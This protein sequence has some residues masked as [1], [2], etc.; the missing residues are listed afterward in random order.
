[1]STKARFEVGQEIYAIH[2][3]KEH[4][5]LN[6]LFS[7]PFLYDMKPVTETTFIKLTVTEHHKVRSS[8]DDKDKEPT[9]DGFVL[10]DENGNVWYNQYPHAEYGQTSTEGDSVFMLAN[11]QPNHPEFNDYDNL[12][13]AVGV[14]FIQCRNLKTV[15]ADM[16]RGIKQLAGKIDECG[17]DN[18][19]MY[20]RIQKIIEAYHNTLVKFE[21][22][23]PGKTI[24][25]VP[26]K[27]YPD[28]IQRAH[29]VDKEPS[30]HDYFD[31][32]AWTNRDYLAMLKKDY[33]TAIS[34]SHDHPDYGV[35][36]YL[37]MM[38]LTINVKSGKIVT[39][40]ISSDWVNEELK[41]T[42]VNISVKSAD[43]IDEF[44]S[45]LVGH[46]TS[47]K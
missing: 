35:T 38:K 13:K 4:D 25:I 42:V 12:M 20:I 7:M 22:Q 26:H 9:Y 40:L 11:R 24:S 45:D 5:S 17:I 29:V 37:D 34:M 39:R 41:D 1:M 10:T 47:G 18:P 2:F 27:T 46:I 33:L 6:E 31:A 19:S 30:A 15:M 8:Y 44:I 14:S 32:G 28:I 16:H 23:Y 43:T 36:V 21:E 3:T